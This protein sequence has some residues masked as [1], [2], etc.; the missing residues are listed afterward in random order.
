MNTDNWKV[1]ITRNEPLSSIETDWI[2]IERESD[3]SFFLSWGWIGT[4]LCVFQPSVSIVRLYCHQELVGIGALSPVQKRQFGIRP[5]PA[6]VL[7]ETGDPTLDLVTL[8]HNGLLVS[9]E[10]QAPAYSAL[11]KA[12]RQNELGS[13]DELLMS[14]MGEE[15]TVALEDASAE[16]GLLFRKTNTLPY[17]SVSLEN[18]RRNNTDYLNSLSRNTRSQIRRS[19]RRYRKHGDLNVQVAPSGTEALEY[20]HELTELNKATWR[21]RNSPSAFEAKE[22]RAFH[23]ALVSE[24]FSSGQIQLVKV[25]AGSH[26]VGILYN[27]HL[28]GTVYHYQS[29]LNYELDGH[30]KPGLT[31]HALAI[32]RYLYNGARVY[33][34]LLGDQQFKRSLSTDQASLHCVSI[35]QAHTAFR[36]ERL[37][38]AA[39]ASLLNPAN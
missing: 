3:C 34:F 18:L 32:E 27:F 29:G 24:R 8:E 13:G 35:R 21:R 23:H 22:F 38:R 11:V 37:V 28:G 1:V 10:N 15:A 36:L 4:W 2:R 31:A 17:F 20:L 39:T 30:F 16:A 25:T 14:W 19:I 26:T 7:N 12:F 9:T 5:Y 6:Q 33:D